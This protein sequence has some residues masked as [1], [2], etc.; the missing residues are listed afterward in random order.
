MLAK[1]QS[2]QLPQLPSPNT[3]Q[4]Q[5]YIPF[6]TAKPTSEQQQEIVDA[7]VKS[8]VKVEGICSKVKN[9]RDKYLNSEK[10]PLNEILNTEEMKVKITLAILKNSHL[11]INN[12]IYNI[13]D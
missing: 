4:N 11:K 1:V 12:L 6:L 10:I 2:F 13:L 3:Q 5:A 7:Y 9:Y 8:N